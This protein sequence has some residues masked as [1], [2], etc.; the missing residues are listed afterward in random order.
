MPLSDKFCY[1]CPFNYTLLYLYLIRYH[2]L[3]QQHLPENCRLPSA[4]ALMVSSIWFIYIIF[5]YLFVGFMTEHRGTFILFF[6]SYSPSTLTISL[7]TYFL[8]SLTDKRTEMSYFFAL[9]ARTINHA[10]N[11][12]FR[13]ITWN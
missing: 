11:G 5:L 6:M 4:V 7:F 9:W 8:K 1:W 3:S 13:L 12:L 10:H 2:L